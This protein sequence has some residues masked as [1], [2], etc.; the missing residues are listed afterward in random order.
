MK[1]NNT[2]RMAQ[3]FLWA[4]LGR[5]DPEIIRMLLGKGVNPLIKDN[6]DK[7]AKDYIEGL[8]SPKT[9]ASYSLLLSNNLTTL[10][11]LQ[12]SLL[13]GFQIPELTPLQKNLLGGF[14]IFSSGS[15]NRDESLFNPRPMI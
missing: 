13:S 12:S 4:V 14:T 9:K 6:E 10:T 1:P 8:V 2:K 5:G 3:L 11:P 7:I 15:E